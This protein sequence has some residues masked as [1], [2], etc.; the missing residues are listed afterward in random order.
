MRS[1]I[2]SC[3]CLYH[4]NIIRQH[5]CRLPDSP[6]HLPSTGTCHPAMRT[7]Y[8]LGHVSLLTVVYTYFSH[9]P[10]FQAWCVQGALPCEDLASIGSGQREV[11]VGGRGT[12][13]LQCM[14]NPSLW[15]GLITLG[16]LLRSTTTRVSR[17]RLSAIRQRF[18]GHCGPRTSSRGLCRRS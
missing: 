1:P 9:Q 2:Q 16:E 10:L 8:S 6:L 13:Q 3:F 4:W 18:P 17:A 12:V 7:A 15:A 11:G 5:A 14:Y